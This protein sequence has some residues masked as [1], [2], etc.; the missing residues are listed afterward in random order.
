MGS[1][2]GRGVLTLKVQ[3]MAWSLGPR[4]RDSLGAEIRGE[5]MRR[6]LCSVLLA[7]AYASVG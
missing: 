2:A 5:E 4:S 6:S 3:E 1:G 7:S